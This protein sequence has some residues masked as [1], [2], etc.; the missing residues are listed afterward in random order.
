MRMLPR[1]TSQLWRD[2]HEGERLSIQR[3][4][5]LIAALTLSVAF[6]KNAWMYELDF[7]QYIGYAVG[8]AFSAS[9]ALVSKFLGL[10]FG[11]GTAANGAAVKEE[12][13]K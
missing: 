8:M 13:K 10:R 7:V 4:I 2:P 9:P 11:S 5:S 1:E 12:E 6:G 3:L